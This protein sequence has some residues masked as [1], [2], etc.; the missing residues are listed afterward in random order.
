M[1]GVRLLRAER[2]SFTG[3]AG[4]LDDDGHRD[5]VAAYFADMARPFG[6]ETGPEPAGQS[7]GEMAKALVAAVPADEPVDL[8]VLAF[9]VHDMWPGR[10]TATYLSHLCPGAPLSFALCDQGSA[11]PFT[12]LRVIRAHGARRALLVVVEQASLPYASAAPL[13]AGHR[14]VALLFG[15]GPDAG[16]EDLRQYTGVEPGAV[17]G[18]ASAA[19][20]GLSA[21]RDAR[22]VLSDALAAVWPGPPEHVR[23]P[24]GQPTTGVWWHLAGA[25]DASADVVVL[26]DYDHGLR[27]L[28]FAAVPVRA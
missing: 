24:A 26:G 9:S 15:G 6:V 25:L 13:P 18:L 8:L 27:Y 3:R 28:S 12:G 10:A 2:G 21:G 16:A 19:V 4:V 22:V 7:Y 20:A 5:E 17:P 11:T 23:V 14:G 1:S